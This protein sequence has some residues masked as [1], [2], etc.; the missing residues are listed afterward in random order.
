MN[1]QHK[2]DESTKMKLINSNKEPHWIG[3]QAIKCFIGTMKFASTLHFET[4]TFRSRPIVN[5]GG[6]VPLIVTKDESGLHWG[7][8]S[9]EF[10]LYTEDNEVEKEPLIRDFN[11]LSI[12]NQKRIAPRSYHL[13]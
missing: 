7:G 6:F 13:T 10:Y 5:L 12:L 9:D 4:P 1:I 2:G 8:V 3:L 11:T